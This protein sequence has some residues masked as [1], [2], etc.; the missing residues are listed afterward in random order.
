MVLPNSITK[1]ACL[2]LECHRGAGRMDQCINIQL[3]R[4]KKL[5]IETNGSG[6]WSFEP[7]LSLNLFLGN[8]SYNECGP[9]GLD[10]RN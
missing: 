2:F 1:P 10:I 4:G 9:I 5:L 8:T 3:Q 6:P 7:I